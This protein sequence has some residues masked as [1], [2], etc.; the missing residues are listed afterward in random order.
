MFRATEAVSGSMAGWMPQATALPPSLAETSVEPAPHYRDGRPSNPRGSVVAGLIAK[1]DD[2]FGVLVSAKKAVH[3]AT[4]IFRDAA[5]HVLEFD[6]DDL[7]QTT[8]A[9]FR[10]HPHINNVLTHLCGGKWERVGQPLRVILNPLATLNHLS[11][12][13]Q[14]I[15]ELLCAE[16]GITGRIL[17]PYFQ[18]FLAK[19][20]P[21]PTAAYL[22]NHVLQLLLEIQARDMS[23]SKAAGEP[24]NGVVIEGGA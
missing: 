1:R 23:P 14:N 2:S 10:H 21:P 9:I 5:G 8:V 19:V 11:P 15:V 3:S 18:T 13:A 6:L 17:K 20:L 7:V 24:R 22:R 16:R 12:L 4:S